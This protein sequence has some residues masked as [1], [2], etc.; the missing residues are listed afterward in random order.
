MRVNSEADR[1]KSA[2][3][4]LT[5][6]L[7]SH[8]Q[9]LEDPWSEPECCKPE[10][11][12]VNECLQP[13]T[14]VCIDPTYDREDE[15]ESEWTGKYDKEDNLIGYGTLRLYDGDTFCGSYEDGQRSGWGVVTSK[16]LGITTLTG[17]WTDNHL[18]GK[19]KLVTQDVTVLEGW[20]TGS[21]LNGP[22]RKIAMKKFRAFRQQVCWLSRYKNGIPYGQC[23]E[24][25]EG[26]GYITGCV[27]E[28]GKFTGKEI[29]FLYPD[30]QTALLGEFNDGVMVAARPARLEAIEIVNDIA[31]PTFTRLPGD[32]VGYSLSTLTSVG[33]NPLTEDPYEQRTCKVE[34]SHVEGGGQGLY[35]NRDIEKGEV[36]AFYNGVRLPYKVGGEKEVWESSGYKIFVNADY[37]SGERIDL[38][39]DLIYLENY[40]ATLGHKMNHCFDYN[41]TEWFFAH[42]RHGVIPCV[43]SLRNIK[44]GEEFFLHYGYDPLNCPSWYKE[45][46]DAYLAENP[47]LDMWQ[48]ADPTRLE[49]SSYNA[50]LQSSF[51]TLKWNV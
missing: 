19:I 6:W 12:N 48:V 7:Q 33:A 3:A 25:K 27:D 49:R 51:E 14:G 22:V 42:P 10:L 43:T 24:W 38:P 44:A 16:D 35:A 45:S 23:W 34:N 13:E 29:A 2:V 5:Q 20:C 9:V 37:K 28:E 15:E 30:L 36:I 1:T 46:L 32:L 11:S 31:V 26:G 41:C 21:K 39:G 8:S 40:R 4:D 18:N 50:C 47:E 17:N